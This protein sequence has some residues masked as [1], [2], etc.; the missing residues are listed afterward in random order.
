MLRKVKGRFPDL[1]EY[2]DELLYRPYQDR[3]SI[4]VTEDERVIVQGETWKVILD[5]NKGDMC[6]SGECLRFY[7]IDTVKRIFDDY[8]Y[9]YSIVN[10][11]RN[12]RTVYAKTREEKTREE[13]ERRKTERD[14]M[15]RK[16]YVEH[17]KE[18]QEKSRE[19]YRR[20]RAVMK[21]S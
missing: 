4:T 9:I 6:F 18:L 2:I 14:E 10:R 8:G 17:K 16:Y 11:D 21:N 7:D 13:E 15:R 19:Y 5:H 12:P 1:Q 20:K 3:L